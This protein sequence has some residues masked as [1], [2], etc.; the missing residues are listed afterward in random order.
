MR[1]PSELRLHT[2]DRSPAQTHNWRC[3]RGHVL[4]RRGSLTI[5][6][7]TA[8]PDEELAMRRIQPGCPKGTQRI[9]DKA[10]SCPQVPTRL[11][12][13]Q[14]QHFVPRALSRRKFRPNIHLLI[15]IFPL[16]ASFGVLARARKQPTS[17]TLWAACH[18]STKSTAPSS[19]T[20]HQTPVMTQRRTATTSLQRK[21]MSTS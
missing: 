14:S 18:R 17:R 11:W 6:R 21:S 2:L 20:H 19:S 7:S 12:C 8:Q 13:R 1:L 16:S 5:W 4:R 15:R 9:K 3:L 10:P